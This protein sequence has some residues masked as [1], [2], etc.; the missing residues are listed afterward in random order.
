MGTHTHTHTPLT[1]PEEVLEAVVA[2]VVPICVKFL[3]G[4]TVTFFIN[5]ELEFWG[6]RTKITQLLALVLV[7]LFI[8][9]F[10]EV[11]RCS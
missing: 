1:C 5:C 7:I 4:A 8:Y 10:F 11:S 9:F 6:K 3:T 2:T